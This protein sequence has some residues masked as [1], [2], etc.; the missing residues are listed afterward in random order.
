MNELLQEIKLLPGVIGSTVHINGEEQIF[1]DLPKVFQA[2]SADIGRSME[3]LFKLKQARDISYIEVKFD[4]SVMLMR[5]VD[6]ESSLI[7][8]CEAGVNF[9]LV[10]MT[11][12]MLVSELK[13][14]VDAIRKGEAAQPAAP[15]PSTEETPK[16]AAK[17]DVNTIIHSGPLASTM[18]KIANALAL[19]IGP[20]SEMV[21]RDAVKSWADSGPAEEARMPE[22]I[23]MLCKEIDD[24]ELEKE[25]L[26]Q[27][28]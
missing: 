26:E 16:A 4:E 20:I 7:T 18:E 23:E 24:S 10:N 13:N 9:P 21:L 15:K 28:S 3:R 14:A 8:I 25:F 22:L 27:V 17:A 1:S 5:P 6:Q 11:S 12:S 2:K 19:A